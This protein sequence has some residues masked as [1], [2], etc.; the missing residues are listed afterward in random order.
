MAATKQRAPTLYIISA[1][2]LSKGLLFVLLGL[3]ILSLIGR[4]LPAEFQKLIIYLKLDPETEFF[5]HL[6]HQLAEVTPAN[7]RWVASGAL[8]YGLL[9]LGEAIGL[10]FRVAWV[11]WVVAAES[12]IFIP[13]EI[14]RLIGHFSLTVLVILLINVWIIWYLLR[15]RQR[16]FKHA[17]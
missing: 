2:K 14:Y 6:E 4:D 16:L 1:I 10:I 11:G 15:N 7:I 17:H 9:S 12:A 13:Y 8:L 5:S 3:G